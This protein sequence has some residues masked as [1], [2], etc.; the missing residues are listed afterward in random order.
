MSK[1]H[2]PIIPKPVEVILPYSKDVSHDN[3]QNSR[4]PGIP[5]RDRVSRNEKTPNSDTQAVKIPMDSTRT[6]RQP[7][8]QRKVLGHGSFFLWNQ[9]VFPL[10]TTQH[11]SLHKFYILLQYSRSFF[12][13]YDYE[14]NFT[15][16][17]YFCNIFSQIYGSLRLF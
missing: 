3:S 14:G 12:F 9:K 11:S 16:P 7:K 8:Y 5:G 4:I 17:L 2:F 13:T 1:Y 6:H 15:F 10:P